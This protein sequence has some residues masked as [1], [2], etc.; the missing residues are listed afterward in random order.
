M[1]TRK[2]TK[3]VHIE[4]SLGRS[5]DRE[6]L[7]NAPEIMESIPVL[8][9][10]N[11]ATSAS[12]VLPGS[13]IDEAP[14]E[15]KYLAFQRRLGA[16]GGV[17]DPRRVAM[18][19]RNEAM[20]EV[21][22]LEQ[23]IEDCEREIAAIRARSKTDR[24]LESIQLYGQACEKA[25]ENTEREAKRLYIENGV[26]PRDAERLAKRIVMLASSTQSKPGSPS[27]TFFKPV[28]FVT[29]RGN[30]DTLAAAKAARKDSSYT[31]AARRASQ[32]AEGWQKAKQDFSHAISQE[33]EEL[34]PLQEEVDKARM[35]LSTTAKRDLE[36]AFEAVE[37]ASAREGAGVSR[38]AVEHTLNNRFREDP[39]NPILVR[40]PDGTTNVWVWRPGE[41]GN[42]GDQMYNGRYEKVIG[43][44]TTFDASGKRVN[45][46][47][48]ALGEEVKAGE[49]YANGRRQRASSFDLLVE[50]PQ[51][52][53]KALAN[54]GNP[55]GGWFASTDSSG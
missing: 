2:V 5:Y 21:H 13:Q 14:V 10:P 47:V 43:V 26:E 49:H 29:T 31:A 40:N 45:T 34:R 46:L 8:A 4:D 35:Q 42:P 36:D 28:R 41:P 11:V 55:T 44:A 16:E 15:D 17:D 39:D 24:H 7:V 25:L 19:K 38:E 12:M 50:D 27:R 53:A 22:R 52:G 54:E 32:Y 33:W 23:T 18:G 37:K 6:Q 1:S 48:T 20:E 30:P 9:P 3:K 51:A